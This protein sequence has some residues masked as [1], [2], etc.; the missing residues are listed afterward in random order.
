[1]P[2]SL[3]GTMGCPL[4]PTE[5]L[6]GSGDLVRGVLSTFYAMDGPTLSLEEPMELCQDVV[7]IMSIKENLQHSKEISS[8][9]M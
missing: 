8:V 4:T 2:H 6:P 7:L 3:S 9:A 5:G 1:M